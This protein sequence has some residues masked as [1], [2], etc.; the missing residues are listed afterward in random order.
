MGTGYNPGAPGAPSRPDVIPEQRHVLIH[1]RNGSEGNGPIIGNLVQA[2]RVGTA[3]VSKN[4]NDNKS[5]TKG[6][7]KYV[8]NI[9]A[10]K[11]ICEKVEAYIK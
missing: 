3:L 8:K 10:F 2:K 1:W 6:G 11:W 4:T 5:E 7:D 9:L